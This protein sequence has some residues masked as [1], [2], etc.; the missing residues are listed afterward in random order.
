MIYGERTN[1]VAFRVSAD[2]QAEKMRRVPF[3]EGQFDEAWLQRLVEQ[4]PSILPAGEV[5]IE[6]APLVCIGTEVSV[7]HGDGRGCID[8]LY[9]T[10]AGHVVIVETKLFR[11]QEA[12]RTVVAQIIDY[13]KE[14]Q[15]WDAE[16]LDEVAADYF[17]RRDGKAARI[18]DEMARLGYLSFSDEGALTDALNRHLMEASFLLLIVGDG[19]R[20]NVYQLAEFLNESAA[21][22]FN[23]ALVEIETYQ[24]DGGYVCVPNL[25]TKT[26]VIE[27]R[28]QP[29]T[30][31]FFREREVMPVMRAIYTP[32]PI[33]SQKDFIATFA[34][35]GG[36]DDDE[37]TEFIG[38]MESIDGLFVNIAPTE[39]TVKFSADDVSS[40]ALLTLS[41]SGG[42]A[43]LYVMPARIKGYLEKHGILPVEVDSFL[44]FYKPYINLA[45][46]KTPPYERPEGFYYAD[47]HQVLY[48]SQ[49]FIEAAEHFI[50]SISKQ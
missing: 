9:V 15:R 43:D 24:S 7:G 27:R 49:K 18:I 41:I 40:C 14:L 13:A 5:G 2:G 30:V 3:M 28:S 11:N 19:I 17:Y 36:I 42:H 12:R 22:T 34:D 4:N 31:S 37:L 23:L 38:D 6:Y 33:M 47:V 20:S 10:P 1:R 21:M 50:N 46:C 29:D 44:D 35:N 26:T 48:D 39:L 45:R 32:K 25:L 16:R 8:N